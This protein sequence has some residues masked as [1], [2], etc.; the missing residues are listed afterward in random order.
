LLRSGIQS[1]KGQGS[2]M[3]TVFVSSLM[4]VWALVAIIAFVK[5]GK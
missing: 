1:K 4:A 2:A 3:T 5:R